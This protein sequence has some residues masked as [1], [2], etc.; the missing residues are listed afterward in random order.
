MHKFITKP[1]SEAYEEQ[2]TLT[3]QSNPQNTLCSTTKELV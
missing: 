2:A 3:T 1:G